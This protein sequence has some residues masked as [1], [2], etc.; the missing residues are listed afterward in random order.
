MKMRHLA[1]AGLAAGALAAE[2]GGSSVVEV[3]SDRDANRARR[4]EVVE[5]V[6]AAVAAHLDRSE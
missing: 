6:R 5:A 3:R 4:D 2:G 1:F